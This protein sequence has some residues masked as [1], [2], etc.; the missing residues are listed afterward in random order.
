VVYFFVVVAVIYANTPVAGQN[1]FP[2]RKLM[3]KVQWKCRKKK[4]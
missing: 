3:S 1:F 4:T 2:N